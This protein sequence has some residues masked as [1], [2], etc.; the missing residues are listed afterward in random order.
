[1]HRIRKNIKNTETEK[2]DARQSLYK[3]IIN[4]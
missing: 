4:A 1:M 3:V 2:K